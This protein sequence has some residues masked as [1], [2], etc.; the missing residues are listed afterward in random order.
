MNKKTKLQAEAAFTEKS[1]KHRAALN[2]KAQ[3]ILKFD[4]LRVRPGAG[5]HSRLT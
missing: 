4:A 2:G 3:A 1:Y 5:R